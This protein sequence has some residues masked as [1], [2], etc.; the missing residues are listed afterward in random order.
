MAPG[1]RFCRA[2]PFLGQDHPPRKGT[3][4]MACIHLQDHLPLPLTHQMCESSRCVSTW[5]SP[6]TSPRDFSVLAKDEGKEVSG[7]FYELPE[8]EV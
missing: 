2:L 6:L 8:A 5:P 3:G 1:P 7:V 4:K